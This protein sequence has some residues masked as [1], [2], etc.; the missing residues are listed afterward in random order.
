MY[1]AGIA[2]QELMATVDHPTFE[3]CAEKLKQLIC[4]V[5]SEFAWI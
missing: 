2:T 1:H 5:G 3:D 4:L